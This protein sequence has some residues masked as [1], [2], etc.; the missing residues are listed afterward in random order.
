VRILHYAVDEKFV[1]FLQ[2]T[3]E[4]AYPGSNRFRIMAG[5]A[6]GGGYVEESTSLKRI[7]DGYWRSPE[8]RGDLDWAECIVL[9]TLNRASSQAAI[10]A[11]KDRLVV[12][13]GWGA[14]YYGLLE[15]Y[16][17]RMH[18]PLTRK[19][20]EQAAPG[21][22]LRSTTMD[23]FR[24]AMARLSGGDW[25]RRALGRFDVISMMPD[26]F[27]LLRRSRPEVRAGFHQLY[28]ASAEDSFLVGPDSM[29][30]ADILLGNSASASNNH[31]EAFEFLR[32]LDLDGRRL[33]VPLSYGDPWYAREIAARGKRLFGDR[34]VPLLEYLPAEEYFRHVSSCGFVLM[35]HV[36]Q[37]ATGNVSA[38]LLKGAKVFLREENLLYPFYRALGAQVCALPASA[39]PEFFAPLDA[40]EAARNRR[41]V[42]DYWSMETVL[43]QTRELAQM[44]ARP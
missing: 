40:D 32:G 18:L 17:G 22:G 5:S 7:A 36:R 24:S 10:A 12:W 6:A 2:K 20:L 13:H 3:Y 16:A 4:L 42:M 37:Q 29:R 41:V 23:L 8:F 11:A 21:A 44:R 28:C 25:R 43:R 35:N 26:E 33:V 31:L 38:A 1:P 34:F 15:G 27:E 9:H 14:D 39:T 30:G 19:L